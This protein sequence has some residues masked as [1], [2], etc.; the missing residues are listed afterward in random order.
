MSDRDSHD[1]KHS[2]TS[3]R[4]VTRVSGVIFLFCKDRFRRFSSPE[5]STQP[6]LDQLSGVHFLLQD[7]IA[8]NKL[9]VFHWHIVDDQSFPYQSRDFP[10]LSEKVR[11]LYQSNNFPML[12]E[13]VRFQ[14]FYSPSGGIRTSTTTCT[15]GFIFTLHQGTLE[16]GLPRVLMVIYLL[17]TRGRSTHTT[18]TCTHCFMFT[19]HQGAFDPY[20][21]VYSQADIAEIIE[22]GRVRG[23][24]IMPEFD[25][26]GKYSYPHH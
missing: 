18:T 1:W 15:H 3:L 13:K 2:A 26:P 24:R 14:Y 10:M 19:L 21:H 23:I 11:F 22:Y 17:S 20:Y 12:S 9:N 6:P 4:S 5:T 8:Y 16:P 25:T 7:A